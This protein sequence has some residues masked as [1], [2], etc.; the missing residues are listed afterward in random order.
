MRDEDHSG[1]EHPHDSL[2]SMPPLTTAITESGTGLGRHV[3]EILTLQ[4][5]DI[6]LEVAFEIGR[7]YAEAL[8]ACQRRIQES[9]VLEQPREGSR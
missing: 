2:S 8:A 7:E 9:Y 1:K 5:G 6:E 3:P 4:F